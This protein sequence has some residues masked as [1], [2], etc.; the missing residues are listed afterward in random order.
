MVRK[1]QDSAKEVIIVSHLYPLNRH[2]FV[3]MFRLAMNVCDKAA[4]K[5][6]LLHNTTSIFPIQDKNYMDSVIAHSTGHSNINVHVLQKNYYF[7]KLNVQI[8]HEFDY[9]TSSK[10]QDI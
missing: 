3:L 6:F 1:L 8:C 5:A 9:Y 10:I 2:I 4:E 7:Q